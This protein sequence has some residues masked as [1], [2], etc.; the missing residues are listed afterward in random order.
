MFKT[1]APCPAGFSGGA[2]AWTWST[3][4]EKE[5][6]GVEASLRT[7]PTDTAFQGRTK[8]RILD[9]SKERITNVLTTTVQTVCFERT[10][11]LFRSSSPMPR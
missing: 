8:Y 11:A 9:L 3:R 10:V 1:D 6:M 7:A 4:R 5:L 2:S